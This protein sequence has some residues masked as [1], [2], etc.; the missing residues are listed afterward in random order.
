MPATLSVVVWEDAS[1]PS[2]SVVYTSDFADIPFDH[3]GMAITVAVV[4][5]DVPVVMPSWA[6]ELDAL[7]ASDSPQAPPP[8]NK[9]APTE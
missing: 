1:D 7:A 2:S 9:P 5:D 3:D 8:V 6:G 4:P